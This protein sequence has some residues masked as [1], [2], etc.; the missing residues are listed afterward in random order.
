MQLNLRHLLSAIEINELGTLTAAADQMHLSQSALTQGINKLENELGQQLFNRSSVGMFAT[1]VGA[2][3]LTRA[4][5]AFDYLYEFASTLY[6]TDKRK[7]QSLVRSITSRQLN[8]FVKVAETHSYTV[9]AARLGLSQPTLHKSIKNLENLCEQPLFHRSPAGVEP[10]WRARQLRRFANLF[11]A[12]IQQGLEELAEADGRMD[13]TIKI[14]SLPLST[15]AIVPKSV[16]KLLALYPMA[17]ATIVDGPY[18]E[19][20]NSL[21]NGHLDVIVGALRHPVPHSDIIQHKL[22]DDPLSLVVK[23]NHPLANVQHLSN[24]TLQQLKWVVPSKG[25][26]SRQVFDDIFLSRG[27]D[28]PKDIIECSALAAIRGILL[29]SERASLLPAKQVEIEV[30]G[31]LLAVCPATIHESRREIGLTV[32]KNWQP[33]QVQKALLRII[34]KDFLM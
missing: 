11:I 9:A 4:N 33:T 15:A 22:F 8:A 34:E 2:R 12:E 25:V 3:F 20:L 5:R 6:S 26:P 28:A 14:G 17:R 10:T 7:R 1:P 19:Q 27:L 23:A 24:E 18:D 16:L 32:R 29:N 13:G 21:L 31:D 30:A